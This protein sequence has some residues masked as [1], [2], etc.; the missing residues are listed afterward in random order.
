MDQFSSIQRESP[1]QERV[2]TI[3]VAAIAPHTASEHF[4]AQPMAHV[5]LGSAAG[6]WLVLRLVIALCK[7]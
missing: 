3:H 1:S 5:L 7:W 2:T 6:N 4:L